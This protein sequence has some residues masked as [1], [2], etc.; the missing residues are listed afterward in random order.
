[1][2]VGLDFV[3]NVDENWERNVKSI[4]DI[5]DTRDFETDII[6]IQTKVFL[7]DMKKN[8]R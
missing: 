5:I 8:I 3:K 4:G 7:K 1:M 2:A 6:D